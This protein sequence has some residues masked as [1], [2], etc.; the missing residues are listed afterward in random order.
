M[1]SFNSRWRAGAGFLMNLNVRQLLNML[2]K[3]MK[4][5]Y[6]IYNEREW[7]MA[8]SRSMTYLMVVS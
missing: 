6:F 5:F 4:D 3:R 1:L 7:L 8:L 2:K